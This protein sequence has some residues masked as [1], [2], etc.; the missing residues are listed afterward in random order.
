[1]LLNSFGWLIDG[2]SRINAQSAHNLVGTAHVLLFPVD[3]MQC[4][5]YVL[6][7]LFDVLYYMSQLCVSCVLVSIF[8]IHFVKCCIVFTVDKCILVDNNK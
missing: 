8:D 7:V 5:F 6:V 2:C 4:P 3:C 1:M